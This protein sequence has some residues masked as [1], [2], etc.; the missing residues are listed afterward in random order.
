MKIECLFIELIYVW[1]SN[2]LCLS[3]AGAKKAIGTIYQRYNLV[4]LDRVNLGYFYMSV[5]FFTFTPRMDDTDFRA[6]SIKRL[7]CLP[8]VH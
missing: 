5:L 1:L 6:E 2:F 4:V 7:L 3:E 8:V